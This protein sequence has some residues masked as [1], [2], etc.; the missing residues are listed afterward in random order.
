VIGHE[1]H[2]Q[3]Q[4]DRVSQATNLDKDTA[5]RAHC[6]TITSSEEKNGEIGK[7]IS[8]GD[9]NMPCPETIDLTGYK[10]ENDYPAQSV[11]SSSIEKT[12]VN[13]G[14]GRVSQALGELTL[15]ISTKQLINSYFIIHQSSK[16]KYTCTSH[17]LLKKF[18]LSLANLHYHIR[19]IRYVSHLCK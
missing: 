11:T 3:T 4:T 8:N 15:K 6:N 13:R 9:T 14:S 1:T 18:S 5:F 17:I 12:N 10:F 16:L 19:Y 2:S 7:S